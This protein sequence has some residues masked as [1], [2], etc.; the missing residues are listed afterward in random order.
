[1][2][3]LLSTENCFTIEFLASLAVSRT[4]AH[5]VFLYH[6]YDGVTCLSP[7]LF[8]HKEGCTE[9]AVFIFPR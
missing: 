6:M 5:K 7:L 2:T 1:M 3:A 4:H 9:T 8:Y